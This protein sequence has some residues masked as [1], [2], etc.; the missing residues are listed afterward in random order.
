MHEVSHDLLTTL[1]PEDIEVA[2][3][4]PAHLSALAG[5]AGQVR[6]KCSNCD[7]AQV[8]DDALLA[9]EITCGGCDTRFEADWGEPVLELPQP[10][11][12][13]E[14]TGSS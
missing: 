3:V 9:T 5:Q 14:E 12:V 11:A 13:D 7:E 2:G 10:A 8:I 1:E 6:V 4:L